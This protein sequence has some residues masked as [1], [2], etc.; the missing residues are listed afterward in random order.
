MIKKILKITGII[1]LLL[2]IS[3]FAIPYFF[4]DQIKAKITEAINEKVDA[5]VSFADADLSFFK[6]FP[7]A[8]VS[9]DKLLIIN[10]A[11]FEGDTLVSMGE[12]NLKMS[13]K[14]L[15]KGKDEPMNIEAI[16]TEN[17][18]INILFN[19][20]GVGNF[21]IALKNEEKTDE[22]SKPLSL[23]IKEY[24]I[25]NLRFKYFDEG[26]KIKMILDSLNHSGTGDFAASKLDLVTKSTAKVSLFMDKINYMNQ[27]PITLDA[28]LGIDL[29]K[30]KYTFKENKALI[31]QLPLEFD[32][33]IQLVENGQEYDLKFKTPTSSFQ[34]FLG[35]IPSAYAGNL[36][37]V[38]TTGDFTVAGFAKGIYSDKTV[39]KFNLAIA[40]NNASFQYPNLPKSVQNIVI[41]TKIINE[42]GLLNDTYV[43]LDKLSFKIDQDVFNAKAISETSLKILW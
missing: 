11:P 37:D 34:N 21:D 15:L 20:D 43:N 6:S 28:V 14:E 16:S 19:K 33:F 42:T 26:S 5:K 10:K 40:S 23:K 9:V 8:N 1:I 13:I 29:D 22:K 12:L 24:E 27:V 31:N 4:K 3:L 32:G 36:K 18:V 35:L 41:D 7:L 30:S 25:E 17:A 38:K 2:A 39:P